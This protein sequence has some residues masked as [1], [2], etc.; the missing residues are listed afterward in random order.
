MVQDRW[1]CGDC[2]RLP[3]LLGGSTVP[4]RSYYAAA[5]EG[6]APARGTYPARSAS[7]SWSNMM[8]HEA[9]LPRVLLT[10]WQPPVQKIPLVKTLRAHAGLSLSEA[11][12][13]VDRCLRGEQVS[14]VMPSQLAAEALVRSMSDLGMRAEIQLP[15]PQQRPT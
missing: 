7:G 9:P 6:A 8:Q 15:M 12:N 11:T 4:H 2:G 1:V 10:G 14:L 3:G 13:A 5:R